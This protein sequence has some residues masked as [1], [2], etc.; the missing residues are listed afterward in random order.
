MPHPPALLHAPTLKLQRKRKE[1]GA[2]PLSSA[3]LHFTF[4]PSP[5]ALPRLPSFLLRQV[6][7]Q[8]GILPL[9]SLIKPTPTTPFYTYSKSRISIETQHISHDLLPVN[10]TARSLQIYSSLQ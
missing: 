4:P 2:T 3:L 7:R 8:A 6:N 5:S 1:K 9:T 10:S